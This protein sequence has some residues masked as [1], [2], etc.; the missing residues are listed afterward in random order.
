MV[1]PPMDPDT[2]PAWLWLL[3]AAAPIAA[4]WA[5]SVIL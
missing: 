3:I 4:T 2:A 1:K 5:V